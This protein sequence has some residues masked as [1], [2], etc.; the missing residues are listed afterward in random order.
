MFLYSIS[1]NSPNALL[2]SG[3]LLWSGEK[4]GHIGVRYMACPYFTFEA[5]TFTRSNSC[6]PE[7]Q[8]ES[9]IMSV[10]ILI[11]KTVLIKKRS[12]EIDSLNN[13]LFRSYGARL[14]AHS[15]HNAHFFF[16]IFV[17]HRLLRERD[18]LLKP[19]DPQFLKVG[20]GS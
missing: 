4:A 10:K 5:F 3:L 18:D 9:N 15:A 16:Q 8:E 1:W 13:R 11:E 7:T 12:V 19:F 6:G 17:D 20:R 14:L 2:Q